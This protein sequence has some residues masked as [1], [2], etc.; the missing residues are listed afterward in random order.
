V[1]PNWPLPW[2]PWHHHFTLW[3]SKGHWT[4]AGSFSAKV[5]SPPLWL[6]WD[7]PHGGPI[8]SKSCVRDEGKTR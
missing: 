3:L 1:D 4:L 5:P 7:Q 2:L 6:S 8:V